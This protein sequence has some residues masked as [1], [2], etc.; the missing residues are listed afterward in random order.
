VPGALFF[1][2]TIIDMD[3]SMCTTVEELHNIFPQ[4]ILIIITG[5]PAQPSLIVVVDLN[6]VVVGASH[7]QLSEPRFLNDYPK[8]NISTLRGL[9]LHRS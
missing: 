3:G 2:C 5:Q 9:G 4:I 7:G 6:C 1:L 8:D